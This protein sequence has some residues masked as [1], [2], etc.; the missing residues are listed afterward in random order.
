MANRIQYGTR[1]ADGTIT[2][3]HIRRVPSWHDAQQFAHVSRQPTVAVFRVVREGPFSVNHVGEAVTDWC[4]LPENA[5]IQFGIDS[6]GT[7]RESRHDNLTCLPDLHDL[8]G[9]GDPHGHAHGGGGRIVYRAVTLH[10][11]YDRI[12][13]ALTNWTPLYPAS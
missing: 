3:Y 9:E 6:G 1:N 5:A 2:E 12:A 10:P 7:V 11:Q 8:T 13:A 4:D